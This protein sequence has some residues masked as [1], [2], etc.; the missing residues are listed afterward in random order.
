MKRYFLCGVGGS[1]ML[2][3]ALILR[4]QGCEVTGS[5]RSLDAGRTA[6]KFEFLKQRGV[7]LFPQDGTGM[8]SGEQIFVASAAVEETVPDVVAAN[9]LGAKRMTR[10][11]LLAELFN[12]APV[13]VGVAGTSGKSTTT[14]M[15]AWILS[16]AGRDPTVMNGAVMKNFVSEETPFASALVGEGEAFVSE[17]D[18]SD[19]S[20]AMFAPTVAVL[21]NIAHDH[22]SM[23]ELR[24]LFGDFV[25]KAHLAILNKDN[26]ETAGVAASAAAGH[27]V[28]YSLE[29]GRADFCAEAIEAAPDGVSFSAYDRRSGTPV[30]AKLTMPGRHNVSNALAA[31][32]AAEACGVSLE[33]GAAALNSFRGVR[34]RL[35]FVGQAGDVSV[36]DDFAHNPDKIAASLSTLKEFPGRLLIIFQPQGY[37]ALKQLKD[38]FIET[39]S[40]HLGK[41]D[42]AFLTAPADFGGTTERTLEHRDAIVAAVKNNGRDLR[43]GA[44]RDEAGELFLHM[45]EPGDRIVI[46]GARDDTLTTFAHGLLQRLGARAASK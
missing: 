42:I 41:D 35:E 1:G 46:M 30:S 16:A 4:A 10:A 22:K 33:E 2:P 29:E 14:A 15:I 25:E 18:E 5:D 12:A 44:S 6:A 20:I 40:E 24:E 43:A 19:G 38:G 17:V 37:G 45:A 34:R 11:A 21:N 9:A 7:S 36:I 13:R 32:L 31:L 26:E 39:F 3:L 28:T 27:V 8:T 23:D